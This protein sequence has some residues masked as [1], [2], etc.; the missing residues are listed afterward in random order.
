MPLG[1]SMIKIK[2]MFIY[3]PHDQITTENPLCKK[4][5]LWY[6]FKKPY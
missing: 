3:V 1:L 5:Y 2:P 6:F 4:H